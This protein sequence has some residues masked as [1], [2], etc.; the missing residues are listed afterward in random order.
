MIYI[1]GIKTF[2]TFNHNLGLHF[3]VMAIARLSYL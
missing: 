3:A 2:F 1:K